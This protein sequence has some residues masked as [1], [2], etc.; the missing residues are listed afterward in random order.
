[1]NIYLIRHGEAEPT[2]V[3]K[4]QEERE[5][6]K[7]GEKIV[8]ASAE[9]WKNY[10]SEF[11]LIFSSPLKR[12]VQTA[13]IIKEVFN[14]KSDVLPEILLLNGGLTEDLL[15]F[16]S[17]L[18]VENIAMIGHQPDIGIHISRI[19]GANKGNIKIA[20]ATISKISFKSSPVMGE[21]I[22]EFLIPPL[23]KKG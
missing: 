10:V 15:I 23:I 20:S 9:F 1:M 14:I 11:E 4:P 19:T 3:N 7:N 22:L 18:G 5:L 2:S 6:T 13:H 16:V 17:T 12:A 21:G 8:K